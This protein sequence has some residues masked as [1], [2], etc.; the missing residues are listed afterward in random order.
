MQESATTRVR[1]GLRA[2]A[3]A[4]RLSDEAKELA[5]EARGSDFDFA[6]LE[7]T[8]ALDWAPAALPRPLQLT[9]GTG[10]SW[11]GGHELGD[12]V[13]GEAGW[14]LL[15]TP[16]SIL[17]LSLSGERQWRAGGAV[18]AVAWRLEGGRLVGQAGDKLVFGVALKRVTGEAANTDYTAASFD[19][20]YDFARPLGPAL[21]SLRATAGMRDYPFYA[22]GPIGVNAG[23]EDQSAGLS[24]EARFPGLQRY[25]YTPKIT[26]SADETLSNISRFQTRNIGLS[27]GFASSF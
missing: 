13:R 9:L 12:H 2:Y 19:L 4:N 25:G 18:N 7:A 17:R 11:Y 24:V 26:L 5:P 15:A 1:L 27:V 14:S 23:R 16:K 10:K 20:G 8:A 21:L 22:L 3:T 6:V